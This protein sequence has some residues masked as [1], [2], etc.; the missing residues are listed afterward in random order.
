MFFINSKKE[1]MG[2][3]LFSSKQPCV[4]CFVSTVLLCVCW[5]TAS[6]VM[7]VQFIMPPWTD[8]FSNLSL[9]HT[10]NEPPFIT[11]TQ[12]A[13][14]PSLK[15]LISRMRLS[16]WNVTSCLWI[17]CESQLARIYAPT[18][19]VWRLRSTF[20]AQHYNHFNCGQ[21]WLATTQD[22]DTLFP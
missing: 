2:Q 21:P 16:M 9:C 20:C 14:T 11:Y 1:V 18:R 22:F 10:A 4:F 7:V 5:C 19:V 13:L 17:Q 3:V 15:G 12:Y 6:G 8:L